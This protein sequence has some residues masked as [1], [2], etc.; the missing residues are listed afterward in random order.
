MRYSKSRSA[1]RARTG[2][3]VVV[4][5]VAT[6]VAVLPSQGAF[7]DGGGES[8]AVVGPLLQIFTFGNDVGVPTGCQLGSSTLGSGSAELGHAA[9][10]AP[11]IVAINNGCATAQTNG[12]TYLAKG[13]TTS[14]PLSAWNP[15][16]NPIIGQTGDSV[17]QFGTDYGDA[18][19]P[20]GGTIAGLGAT[21]NFFQGK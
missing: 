20:F 16:V 18:L 13:K 4:A 10:V 17:E 6:A 21:I 2:R 15:Y 14:Q 19:A 1:G 12:D 11:V 7:A 5:A 3:L 9:E 8:P